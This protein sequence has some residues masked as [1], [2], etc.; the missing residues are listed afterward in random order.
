MTA[1]RGEQTAVR[2][3][4]DAQDPIHRSRNQAGAIRGDLV[5]GDVGGGLLVAGG[6]GEAPAEGLGGEVVDVEPDVFGADF[7]FAVSA[8]A[9]F[10]FSAMRPRYS[11]SWTPAMPAMSC[12]GGRTLIMLDRKLEV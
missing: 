7:G 12:S 2:Y 3:L 8:S 9:I 10:S 4:P 5:V 6:P 11:G 1:H